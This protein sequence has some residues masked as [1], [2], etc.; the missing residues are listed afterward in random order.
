MLGNAAFRGVQDWLLVMLA[1]RRSPCGP[2]PAHRGRIPPPL[3][4]RRAAATGPGLK[5]ILNTTPFRFQWQPLA[6]LAMLA[7]VSVVPPLSRAMPVQESSDW[8]VAAVDW[9]ASHGVSGRFFADPNDGAYLTWRLHDRAR[10]Y[11]DTRGFF[12][13]PELLEDCQY[14]PQL[15]VDW[16][17]RLRHV[18]SYGTDYFLLKTDGPHGALWQAIEPHIPDPLY[19]DQSVVLLRADQVKAGLAAYEQRMAANP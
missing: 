2:T 13:P 4:V 18:D 7:V 19:R 6:A 5:R 12:F 16:P 1:A 9:M 10:C 8:P 3:G 15:S 11:A 14:L 17:D